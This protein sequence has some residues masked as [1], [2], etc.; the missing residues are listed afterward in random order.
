MA[1][2]KHTKSI[3]FIISMLIIIFSILCFNAVVIAEEI[4][5][6]NDYDEV[7]LKFLNTVIGGN[8]NIDEVEIQAE[9]DFVYDMNLNKLGVIYDLRINETNGYAIVIN[10]NGEP[11]VAEMFFD[12]ESPYGEA[13]CLKVYVSQFLYLEF[14]DGNYF[15]ADSEEA[16]SE[17]QINAIQD[18]AYCSVDYTITYTN[19]TI[20]YMSKTENSQDIVFRHP[21]CVPVNGYSNECAPVAGANIVQFFDRYK[22]NL[23]A[24]YTPGSALGQSYLYKEFGT[25]LE[26]VVGQLYSDMGTNSVNQGTTINQFKSGLSTYCERKGY[27]ITYTSCMSNGSLNYNLLKEN[28]NDGLPIVLFL[29]GFTISE[30]NDNGN[31]ESISYNNYVAAHVMV[32]FGYREVTY[33]LS[34]GNS[35]TDKYVRVASGLNERKRGYYNINRNTT[36]DD[37]FIVEIL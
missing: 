11:E 26:S 27:S 28:I 36:I 30:N 6:Y 37:A 18:I 29:Y 31:S 33:T 2:N 19:E 9:K 12:A 32:G 10:V 13:D 4:E 21:A 8:I 16:L 20:N 22:T 34:N 35:R 15:S 14:K 3:M 17:A 5:D 23:I 7:L 25:E 1:I 24:N